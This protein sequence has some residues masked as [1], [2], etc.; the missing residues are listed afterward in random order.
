M[1]DLEFTWSS[2]ICTLSWWIQSMKVSST[3]PNHMIGFSSDISK[4]HLIRVFIYR[5]VIIGDNGSPTSKSSSC[6]YICLTQLEVYCLHLH[7]VIYWDS[8]AVL[9]KGPIL[10][11]QQSFIGENHGKEARNIQACHPLCRILYIV[12]TLT[13]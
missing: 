5:F 7:W 13:C 10:S 12:Q 9:E 6:W 4:S 3:Y 11:H 1:E 8:H 2:S